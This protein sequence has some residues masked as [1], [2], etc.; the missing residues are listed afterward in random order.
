MSEK[1]GF[2]FGCSGVRVFGWWGFRGSNI[3][4]IFPAGPGKGIETGRNVDGTVKR[5]WFQGDPD[6]LLR[7]RFRDLATQVVLLLGWY[8]LFSNGRVNWDVMRNARLERLK[9]QAELDAAGEGEGL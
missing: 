8:H 9:A 2:V 6:P 7:D 5:Y 4:G 3:L 1:W